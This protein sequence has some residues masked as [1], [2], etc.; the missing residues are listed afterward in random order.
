MSTFKLLCQIPITLQDRTDVDMGPAGCAEVRCA[1]G[2]PTAPRCLNDG[3]LGSK[4]LISWS[5]G[6]LLANLGLSLRVQLLFSRENITDDGG[7]NS[8]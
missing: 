2:P 6:S 8:R 4:K 1:L 7:R 5:S 3:V